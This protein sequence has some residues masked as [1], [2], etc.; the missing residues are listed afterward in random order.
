MGRRNYS[1]CGI[2]SSVLGKSFNRFKTDLHISELMGDGTK[3]QN[4]ALFNIASKK[5]NIPKEYL[6]NNKIGTEII[7]NGPKVITLNEGLDYVEF[8]TSSNAIIDNSSVDTTIPGIYYVKYTLTDKHGY[9]TYNERV[10]NV[11]ENENPII[12]L[13]GK[14]PDI[15]YIDYPYNDPGVYTTNNAEVK[16]IIHKDKIIY[17]AIDAK[18]RS[19]V[20][21][22]NL[23]LIQIPP[24]S[25]IKLLGDNP[26]LID[27]GDLYRDPGIEVDVM[28]DIKIDYGIFSN[29]V[30]GEYKI[31]ITA[32]NMSGL[33]KTVRVIKVIPK[34]FTIKHVGL[35]DIFK[36]KIDLDEIIYSFNKIEDII[37]TRTSK[38]WYDLE[39]IHE[40]VNYGWLKYVEIIPTSNAKIYMKWNVDNYDRLLS[41]PKPGGEHSQ[42][43]YEILRIYLTFFNIHIVLPKFEIIPYETTGDFWAIR[44][45]KTI[46]RIDD[47][48]VHDKP[49]FI[50]ITLVVKRCKKMWT[51]KTSIFNK[52]NILKLNIKEDILKGNVYPIFS[53]G[54]SVVEGPNIEYNY[55]DTT[56]QIKYDG[57]DEFLIDVF[58]SKSENTFRKKV[59][60]KI[61]VYNRS[62]IIGQEFH[63]YIKKFSYLRI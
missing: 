15:K 20:I 40:K 14:N 12:L 3:R 22:R 1:S 9:T 23:N 29:T 8:G 7:L 61:E 54:D 48:I 60:S 10:V 27:I 16:T 59:R 32:E 51:G 55:K 25:H 44:S 52:S 13:K 21:T 63:G 18:G 31:T 26:Y 34:K 11:I 50:S 36:S 24:P 46:E 56:I 47:V 43:Y 62:L 58:N 5:F 19:N 33:L 53:F 42:V 41:Y 17:E 37:R 2:I 35:N 57:F 49:W 45:N 38:N 6:F 30:P 28:S 39:I 4:S